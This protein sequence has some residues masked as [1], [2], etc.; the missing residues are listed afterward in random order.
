VAVGVR[1]HVTQRGNRHQ[2]VFFSPE[3]YATYLALLAEGCRAARDDAL[4]RVEP[5]LD[6]AP[7][8]SGFLRAGVASED[9]EAIRKSERTGRPLGD[10]RFVARLER[11]LGRTL[12]P[13]KPGPKSLATEN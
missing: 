7:D 4:V 10:A 11:K 2:A 12:K 8:W 9:A 1:H 5:L 13:Q 6:L 3:D